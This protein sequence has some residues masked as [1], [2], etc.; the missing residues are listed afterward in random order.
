MLFY[1]GIFIFCVIM[2]IFNNML[3]EQKHKRIFE[4]ITLVVL[5]I[6]SGTRYYLGGT[7]YDVYKNMFEVLPNIFNFDFSNVHEIYGTFGAEKGYLFFNSIVKTLG[8]NFF[9]FTLIH[10][11][12]FYTCM[13]IG[14]KRYT[15]NFNLL[16]IVFLYKM[17]FYDTFVSLRQTMTIAIFFV[18]LRFIEN[19]K[20]IPYFLCCLLAVTF[21]NGALILF[22][23]YF[24]NKFK[25]TKKKLVILNCIFIP[26][27]LVSMLNI[28]ILSSFEWIINIFSSET[29]IEKATGLV[30]SSSTSG[31]G[32]LHT[33]EYLAIMFLVIINYSKIIKQDKNAEFII[34]LFVILLPLFTL[35]RGYEILTREK[36][37]FLFTYAIILGY[38]CKMCNKKY[39]FVTQ[40]VV[41]I[42]CLL[43]FYRDII[44]FGNGGLIPF[45]TYFTKD[46]SI[47]K[48]KE[49]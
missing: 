1:V 18:S 24:I 8:F 19:K 36:D 44:G 40:T 33:L 42:V 39:S 32:F 12:I 13:Y 31:I 41:T 35:F 30:N 29:A 34:K 7:D 49:I 3:K 23:V 25:L 4:I 15:N 27:L 26:T 45:Q 21:H 5:C 11:I 20:I 6:I 22:L 28:P 2:L 43:G 10:S 9:G 48:E 38:L 47:F 37:Y 14:L 16:I 17:F 46:V